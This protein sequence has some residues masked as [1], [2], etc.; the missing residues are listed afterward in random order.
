MVQ[1]TGPLPGIWDEGDAVLF[2]IRPFNAWDGGEVVYWE[3]GAAP[4][5]LVHGGHRWDTAFD[6]AGTF[7][8]NVAHE[9]VDAL[10]AIPLPEPGLAG[11]LCGV[12]LLRTLGGRRRRARRGVWLDAAAE[13]APEGERQ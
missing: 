7:G 10:E 8:V 12:G 11:L 4:E 1:D 3:F 13:R 2:S 6:V 9:N 5:F